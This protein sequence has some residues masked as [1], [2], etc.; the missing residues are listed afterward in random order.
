MRLYLVALCGTALLAV[1]S[2]CQASSLAPLGPVDSQ[3]FADGVRYAAWLSP[4]GTTVQD[5]LSGTS[6]TLSV[7]DKCAQPF[8]YGIGGG[9]VLWGCDGPFPDHLHAIVGD[10]RTGA[11]FDVPD[12]R[13]LGGYGSGLWAVG[14]SWVQFITSERTVMWDTYVNWRTG[15]TAG[16]SAS[17]ST[18]RT[19]PS[20]NDAGLWR[21]LCAPLR[22]VR[23]P[24]TDP[25]TSGPPFDAL[26]YRRPYALGWANRQQ[27]DGRL[28][29]YRCGRRRSQVIAR[30]PSRGCLE[31]Q[32]GGG[33][34]SWLDLDRRLAYAFEISART[35]R[36]WPIPDPGATETR[37]FHTANR[38]FVSTYVPSRG[39]RAYVGRIR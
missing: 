10:V 26:T 33:A 20:L 35:R 16:D 28:R 9:F 34:V 37:V 32:L 17:G 39:F 12:N 22:R 30:C 5:T 2:P 38:L 19:A 15:E 24:N 31:Q 14:A 29:L 21:P 4:A 11:T 3:V 23:N 27:P 7:A 25:D 8:L 36:R 18:A 13:P 1:A 6:R